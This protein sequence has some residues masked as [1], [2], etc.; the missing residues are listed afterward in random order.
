MFS[1]G[2][3]EHKAAEQEA[4]QLKE[5]LPMKKRVAVRGI[6]LFVMLI[7]L[8]LFLTSCEA[9]KPYH[10][11]GFYQLRRELRSE[12]HCLKKLDCHLGMQRKA[13][14]IECIVQEDAPFS[15][16]RGTYER[17]AEYLSSEEV[18]TDYLEHSFPDCTLYPSEPQSLDSLGPE[19]YLTFFV[20]DQYIRVD[21]LYEDQEVYIDEYGTEQVRWVFNGFKGWPD[22]L[23]FHEES[24]TSEPEG[25]KPPAGARCRIRDYD[26]DGEEEYAFAF[27]RDEEAQLWLQEDNAS[28]GLTRKL[29]TAELLDEI[30]AKHSVVIENTRRL[31]DT[32]V[33]TPVVWINDRS[34]STPWVFETEDDSFIDDMEV[35]L[36]IED[37]SLAQEL[38]TANIRVYLLD[39][40]NER[41]ELLGYL[42]QDLFYDSELGFRVANSFD[43]ESLY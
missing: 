31:E 34:F 9:S 3:I 39:K 38:F 21:I 26:G 14:S 10:P 37:F 36:E 29:L 32:T 1:G 30:L 42:H 23:F 13:L 4:T 18:L 19:M 24:I 25:I 16:I 33:S 15:D 20:G 12:Y 35:R 2:L 17:L 41:Q 22:V 6:A 27:G 7:L 8:C 5:G 28:D 43:V 40:A 11:P